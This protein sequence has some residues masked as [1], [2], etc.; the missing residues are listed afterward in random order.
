MPALPSALA[1]LIQIE[2]G[3]PKGGREN[4]KYFIMA[5]VLV[6]A[7]QPLLLHWTLEI[8]M[9]IVGLGRL[10]C[11]MCVCVCVFKKREKRD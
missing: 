5:C 11:S 9:Q 10:V 4:D 8:K 6:L 1:T 7:W 3:M 2:L